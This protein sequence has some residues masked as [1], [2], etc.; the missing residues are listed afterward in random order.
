MLTATRGSQVEVTSELFI[1]ISLVTLLLSVS[2]F[3]D[4]LDLGGLLAA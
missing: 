1:S 4:F 3:Y 2:K